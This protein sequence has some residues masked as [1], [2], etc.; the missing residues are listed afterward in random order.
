MNQI[1]K[2][3]RRKF[4]SNL[5]NIKVYNSLTKQK[6]PLKLNNNN[7]LYW[8]SCGNNFSSKIK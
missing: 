7:L 2:V 3:F 4:S 8:Y 5:E 6:E 1:L